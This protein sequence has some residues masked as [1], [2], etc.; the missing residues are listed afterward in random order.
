MTDQ[1]RPT[2]AELDILAVLWSRKAATVREVHEQLGAERG[3]G[4][5]TTLKLMQL[6][7]AKGL[8]QRDERER[9][10]VYRAAQPKSTAQRQILGRLIA[11]VFAGSTSA[12]VQQALDAG[13]VDAAELNEIRRMIDARVGRRQP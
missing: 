5:T 2:E 6:M 7:A 10:H 12:L 4:Y 8:V 13:S 3:T 1:P 11:K 9:S